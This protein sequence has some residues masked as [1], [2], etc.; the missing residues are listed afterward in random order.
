MSIHILQPTPY[1]DVNDFLNLLLSNMQAILGGH[2][3]GLYLGG[4]L[5]LGDFNPNR[6]DID[7]V[8]V[9]DDE[10]P[11][12]TIKALGKMHTR[13][14]ATGTKWAMKL[15]GSYVPQ[16]VI[17]HWT[18][19]EPPCPFVEGDRFYVTNQ[20]SAVIQR[21]IIRQYGVI[22]AG[23]SPHLL[24]DLVDADDLRNALRENLEKWWR[25]LL[26]DP[27]WVQ[28]SQ[29]Q[30]FAILT[31]CRAL[32]TL[33]HGIVASKPVAARWGQQAISKQWTELIQWALAWPHDTQSNH[34]AS[35][36]SLIQY[37]LK[38]YEYWNES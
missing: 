36:L 33:E 34:L 28:E 23:P 9:T 12:E 24:I 6:S 19:D 38:R 3:V 22:V 16:Q 1:Q 11:L 26:D 18:S 4:S 10:S 15:D 8:A 13:L 14:R 29:K 20:G 25:P 37:T 21:H 7:F 35:T 5:A 31:M 27:A 30:P 17:R 32:Y 2:F